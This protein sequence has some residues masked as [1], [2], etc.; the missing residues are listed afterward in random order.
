MYI[1]I[2]KSKIGHARV[3][4]ADLTYEGSIT[5]DEN[6]MLAVDMIA[7]EKVDVLNLNNGN[8]FTT[9]LIPGPAGSGVICLNGPA[10]RMGIIGDTVVI[11][12]YAFAGPDEAKTFKPKIVHLNDRNQIK[13]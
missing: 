11:I 5:V 4:Q 3:T 1:E 13:S 7:G 8:R 9:Y 2:L 12:S 10:A 6:L